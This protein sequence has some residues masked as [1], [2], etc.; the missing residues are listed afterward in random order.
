MAD[1]KFIITLDIKGKDELEKII[2]EIAKE[3]KIPVDIDIQKIEEGG[4]A[5]N[6]LAASF[7]K[8]R[9]FSTK[10]GLAIHGAK[11]V[12]DVLNR[13]IG[14]FIRT[15]QE[16]ESADIALQSALR[17]TGLEVENNV[18]NLSSY[19]DEL[20]NVTI[21]DDEMI[22]NTMS[23]MQNI[24]KFSSVETLEQATKAAMGLA[25]A[26][27]MDLNTAMMLVGKAAAGN[28][29]MLGRYGIVLDE[30]A[31]QEEK[32]NQVLQIGASYFSISEERAKSST[33]KLEQLK[34]SW[35]ELKE[36]LAGGIVPILSKT[37]DILKPLI[38]RIAGAKDG[39]ESQK[40]VILEQRVE[41]EKLIMVYEN[42]HKKTNRSAEENKKY[43]QTIQELMNTYPNYFKGLDLEKDSWYSI[44]KAI[45]KARVNLQNYINYQISMA[46]LDENKKDLVK[47]GS[48][49]AKSEDKL[50][51]LKAQL[52]IIEEK[53]RKKP[54]DREYAEAVS[55]KI[56]VPGEEKPLNREEIIKK[57]NKLE[58]EVNRMKK[59]FERQMDLY[60]R[61]AENVQ[62][63]VPPPPREEGAI[64][65]AVIEE[66]T[67]NLKDVKSEYEALMEE[68]EEYRRARKNN[69]NEEQIEIDKLRK[70]YEDKFKLV[71]KGSKE[72]KDLKEKL[73]REIAEIQDK[74][75]KQREAL[76]KAYYERV[77]FYDAGYYDWK[78]E[79]IEKEAIELFGSVEKGSDWINEQLKAL[80]KER[81]GLS[82]NILIKFMEE[83]EAEISH[84]AELQQLGIVTYDEIARKSWEYYNALKEI[85]EADG[86][87]T[88]E[89]KEQLLILEKRAQKAQLAV[90]RYSDIVEYYNQMKFLDSGY[91]EWKKARIIEDVEM[92]QISDEQKKILAD[93][94]IAELEREQVEA[95]KRGNIFL[96]IVG[97]NKEDQD[98]IIEQYQTVSN[99]IQSIW[100]NMYANLD[101]ERD[102]A[103]KKIEERAKSEHKSDEWLAKEKDK[104]EAEYEKKYR[105]MKK[106]E[107]S[108][109]I[110][111][112]L[113]NTYEGI[114]N[115]LT[116]KPVWLAP[117]FAATIGTLG[118]A[119]VASIASQKFASGGL[120]RGYG[121]TT[122][123]SNLV[124]LSDQEYIISADR[125]KKIGVPFLDALNFGK[126]ENIKKIINSLSLPAMP[127]VS[128][129]GYNN[130]GVVS[131]ERTILPT[132][133]VTLKCDS[134]EL[135]RAVAKGNKKII[136]T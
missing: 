87:I 73:N 121:T 32:F 67:K 22:K 98:K 104:I 123:D 76:E 136:R 56:Y 52:K 48:D 5:N 88:D 35:G 16:A 79:Q 60:N 96:N 20:M 82:A 47:I 13:T 71:K 21:Y 114:T 116:I 27:G 91:Y 12:Y 69:F 92:M 115:A 49:L 53:E 55:T 101:S 80:D 89:E 24:A 1:T 10:A 65:G 8:V 120:F 50:N 105:K 43:K 40:K 39:L 106:V 102:E 30:T 6:L 78:K 36:M 125:V 66:E 107:Q 81:E 130:G 126:I 51:T 109:Q 62:R 2:Q 15:A 7:E 85:V 128:N 132:I 72:E 68:I 4:K 113:M 77:K 26:F 74:Y 118:M 3:Q 57:I 33:G 133:E 19:A 31:S 124:A 34:N 9:L 90:N 122:S 110:S 23:T 37:V 58:P 134:R 29:A 63:L 84:L 64:K 70:E 59:E 44:E 45:G 94:L 83:Y 95:Q 41:F 46:V 119:Q 14:N 112:A 86:I 93:K 103:L 100:S 129:I 97:I 25:D 54:L 131:N 18:R 17:A 75:A 38:D 11:E 28:T 111:S 135:A 61:M 117:I 42:L 108:M 99:Q 127:K